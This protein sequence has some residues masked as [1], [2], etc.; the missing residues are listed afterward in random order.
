MKVLAF[1][2]ILFDIFDGTEKL[3]GAPLNFCSDM[4]KMGAQGYM[5][6][7]V[8]DDRLGQNAINAM[9][10]VGIDYSLSST[11]SIFG[12]GSCNVT[13]NENGEPSYELVEGV[14]YDHITVSD[15]ETDR[16]NAEQ[17]DVFYFGTLSQRNISSRATL[18]KLLENCRFGKVFFDINIRQT[19]Y[20]DDVIRAGL[21]RADILKI[22]YSE[23][24]LLCD[25][26]F[27]TTHIGDKKDDESLRGI[28]RELCSEYGIETVIITL[29]KDGACAYRRSDDEY[30][31]SAP[32]Q[33]GVVSTVGAGDAFSACFIYNYMCGNSLR[34]CV[35]RANILGDYTVGYLEAIP[36]YT[37]ELLERITG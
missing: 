31:R 7:A 12:T 2:E 29:D 36:P 14:A 13:C 21:E 16:I 4:V 20:S 27:C 15:E 24:A 11:E 8:S 9:K 5:L 17:F 30:Y 37:D 3:G 33:S 19:Y 22:N 18:A 1:G 10:A 26:G 28:S 25:M 34:E 32:A 35:D 6:S 23:C